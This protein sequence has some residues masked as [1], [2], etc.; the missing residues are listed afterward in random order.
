MITLELA[1]GVIGAIILIIGWIWETYE[2][3]KVHKIVIHTHFAAL[4][5]VGNV[6][7]AYYSYAINSMV[8]FWLT[9]FLLAAIIFELACSK[10]FKHGK[11]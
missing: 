8:F 1:L 4:Y 6:L 2:S 7:L 5:I 9:I 3:I 10:F 11:K